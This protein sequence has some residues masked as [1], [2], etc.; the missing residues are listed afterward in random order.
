MRKRTAAAP[1]VFV[2]PELMAGGPVESGGLLKEHLEAVRPRAALTARERIEAYLK[3]PGIPRKPA[4]DRWPGAA[5]LLR[6]SAVQRQRW[7]TWES[8]HWVDS[9]LKKLLGGK[10]PREVFDLRAPKRDRPTS[11][12]RD[13]NICAEV[14]RLMERG[15]Y[16]KADAMKRVAT[17]FSVSAQVV[18]RAAELWG[19]DAEARKER[20]RFVPAW[21][22]QLR[23]AGKLE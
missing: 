10:N 9:S 17:G 4:G 2:V 19:W 12:A 1:K 18:E 22:Q 11:A 3:D 7:Q 21:E 6:L 20:R 16:S 8:Q 23:A 5:E 14:L 13:R 15:D